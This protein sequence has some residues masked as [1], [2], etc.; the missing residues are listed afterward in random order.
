MDSESVWN[1]YSSLPKQI[2]EIVHLVGFCYKNLLLPVGTVATAVAAMHTY[3]G[4]VFRWDS[5]PHLI[6]II[7][8][9]FNY[10]YEEQS[11]FNTTSKCYKCI[12][13]TS[14]TT[15]I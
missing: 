15:I 8:E 7:R 9:N 4:R 2:W 3:C 10:S 13:F 5:S 11:D 6:L 12:Y 14:D 1:T